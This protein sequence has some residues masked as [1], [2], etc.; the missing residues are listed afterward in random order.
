MGIKKTAKTLLTDIEILKYIQDYEKRE[1]PIMNTLWEYYRGKNVKILKRKSPDENNPDNRI[2]V[3]YAKKIVNTFTGYAYRPTFI[4]YKAMEHKK[5]EEDKKAGVVYTV[6]NKIKNIGTEKGTSVVNNYYKK[7]QEVFDDNKEPIKTNRAG[8][9]TAIFGVS[10]EILYI[11]TEYKNGVDKKM[12]M[13]NVPKFFTVDPRELI[14]LYD[15]SPEPKKVLAIRFFDTEDSNVGIVEVY[16]AD[17]V[18]VYKRIREEQGNEWKEKLVF[19][20]EYINFFGEVPIIAFYLGDEMDGIFASIIPLIDAYDVLMSDSMNE[21][22]RFA[23]AYLVMKQFGLSNMVKKQAPGF[24]NKALQVLR[25][26]RLFEHLPKDA[27]I[28]FL[29]KDIPVEFITYMSGILREQIHIQ[30]HVPDFTSDKMTGASGIA[31]QRLLFDF[32]NIV[33][34]A[35]ADFNVG[36]YERI[37]LITNYYAMLPAGIQ[38]EPKNIVITH[39]R[40]IPTNINDYAEAAVKLKN[41]GFS[42]YLVAEIMPDDIIPD[43]EEELAR[44][45][46]DNAKLFDLDEAN[47]DF[48]DEDDSASNDPNDDGMDDNTKA[49]SDA[50]KNK[51]GIK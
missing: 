11:D 40:N 5:A 9:N 39:K 1:I 48:A 8:R 31:I 23:F 7:I 17:K 43:V 22:D 15:F 20:R 29:T 16:S 46:E 21:F 19:D 41:A 45:D 6:I 18:K 2:P 38:G 12:A 13:N 36:L 50:K 14:L 49:A 47:K 24:E 32:E 25:H 34:S 3:S 33:A 37:A 35:E 26:R 44:Q 30:S 28:S 10:Y 51:E 4:T 27:E 42:R